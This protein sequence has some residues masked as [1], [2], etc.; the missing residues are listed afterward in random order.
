[1]LYDIYHIRLNINKKGNGVNLNTNHSKQE[2]ARLKNK[3]MKRKL[4]GKLLAISLTM[5]GFTQ[6]AVATD[7]YFSLAYGTKSKGMGGAGV[8]IFENSLFGASN[9]AGLVRYGKG[10]GVAAGLFSPNRSYTVSGAPTIPSP[11]SFP[12]PF[13][14]AE[15]KVTSNSKLFVMPALAANFMIGNTNAIGLSLYG[16][17]GMNTN[18]NAKTFYAKYLDGNIM[19]DGS[20]PMQGVSKPTGVNLMQIFMAIQYSHGFGEKWSIGLGPIVGWQSFEA[21]GLQAFSNFGMSES[22]EN[23]TNRGADRVFGIG[24]KVGI[25]G[26]ITPCLSVGATFQ[27]PIYMQKFSKYSGLFAEKG[28]FNV[29]ATWTAGIAVKATP[30]IVLALDAKQIF[31]SK[32]KSIG[33]PI[34]PQALLPMIPNSSGQLIQNPNYQPLG[35][36]NGSGFG[37]KDM[38]ILKF[39]GEYKIKDNSTIRVGYSWGNNPIKSS[40]VL[41]NILA[42]GVIQNHITAGFTQQ[43]GNKALDFAFV[44]AFKNSVSGKNQ[45]DPAQT[46]KLE[47]SQWEFEVGFRF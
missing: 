20:N 45:F 42:P 37:W 34:N 27:T 2:L 5:I 28:G 12:P 32:I 40:Q 33:N 29:P 3:I 43:F 38:F 31:Y 18:Y 36:T 9:P 22:P 11:S 1:M 4:A 25:L 16:N 14:L 15:G 17:G 47:M 30:S 35:S 41:F 24:G 10:Y 7:G 23:L 19:P 21:K 44:Y 39:G 26:Q 6:V 13:G 46:I 8:A